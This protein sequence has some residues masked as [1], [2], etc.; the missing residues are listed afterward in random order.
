MLISATQEGVAECR[1][2]I[3]NSSQLEEEDSSRCSGSS[4]RRQQCEQTHLTGVSDALMGI[5]FSVCTEKD[6][7]WSRT[8]ENWAPDRWEEATNNVRKKWVQYTESPPQTN[9]S[10]W[11]RNQHSADLRSVWMSHVEL[12]N[13]C[14]SSSPCQR[15]STTAVTGDREETDPE[16]SGHTRKYVL[17]WSWP[18]LQYRRSADNETD[19]F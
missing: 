17:I 10:P 2:M 12:T 11:Q 14:V 3:L 19:T 4:S 18:T 13:R 15:L 9:S 7:I 8:E 5:I 6:Q 16:Q 1:V